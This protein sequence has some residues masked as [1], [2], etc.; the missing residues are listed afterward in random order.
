MAAEL[1]SKVYTKCHRVVIDQEGDILEE[2][3]QHIRVNDFLRKWWIAV[4]S[5]VG[6]LTTRPR[7]QMTLDIDLDPDDVKFLEVIVNAPHRILVTGNSDFLAIRDHQRI[8][9]LGVRILTVEE[10]LRQL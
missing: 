3:S 6:K 5:L 2:Y 8:R 4:S 1:L 10:A 9:D 7:A